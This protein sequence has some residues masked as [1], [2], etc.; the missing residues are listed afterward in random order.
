MMFM[1]FSIKYSD[2][3]LKNINFIYN[4]LFRRNHTCH[5]VNMVSVTL[6]SRYITSASRFHLRYQS[7]SSMY[8]YIRDLI[9]RKFAELAEAVPIQIFLSVRIFSRQ[10]DKH[11][12]N[13][14][15]RVAQL[16]I[17]NYS[18]LWPSE[19]QNK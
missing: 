13:C 10:T 16:A 4:P 5:C 8:M 1:Y 11:T 17:N 15:M 6:A 7:R 18:T 12:Y 19:I 3:L 14:L 2:I 9:L